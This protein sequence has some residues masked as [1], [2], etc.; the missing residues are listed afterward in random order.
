MN[1]K[2]FTLIEL[3]VVVAILSILGATSIYQYAVYREGAFCS[4]IETDVHNTITTLEGQYSYNFSYAGVSPV[5]TQDNGISIAIDTTADSIS[6]VEGSH[7]KCKKGK[8][9]FDPT[10]TPTYA[11]V[12]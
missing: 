8:F 6:S 12:P 11:W 2:G 4:R 3:L 10:A 7:P 5:Q 9:K 1:N